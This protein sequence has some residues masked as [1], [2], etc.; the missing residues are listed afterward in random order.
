MGDEINVE[1]IRAKIFDQDNINEPDFMDGGEVE[2]TLEGQITCEF[3]HE[4]MLNMVKNPFRADPIYLTNDG[5][6]VFKFADIHYKQYKWLLHR[7][8]LLENKLIDM[9]D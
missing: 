2:V 8:A 6:E 1:E 3:Q 5:E 4:K 7:M 9:E